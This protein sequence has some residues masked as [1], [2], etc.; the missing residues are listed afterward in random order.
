MTPDDASKTADTEL[1][2]LLHN[3]GPDPCN[4]LHNLDARIAYYIGA[5]RAPATHRAYAADIA[6]FLA[7]G[8]AIPTTP[9][10]VAAYLA[11]SED[12]AVS[13]LRRRLAAI[14]DAHQGGG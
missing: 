10:D 3:N 1:C 13:T 7:W 9:Q 2:K 4:R 12:L 6:A 5:A 11:S 14:A 8:G